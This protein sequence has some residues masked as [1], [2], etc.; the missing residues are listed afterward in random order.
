MR[1]VHAVVLLCVAMAQ[2]T[3]SV[4]PLTDMSDSSSAVDVRYV[5]PEHPDK[6]ECVLR[7]LA[8]LIVTV[9]LPD[10]VLAACTSVISPLP[11]PSSCAAAAAAAAAVV[12]AAALLLLPLLLRAAIALRFDRPA[13]EQAGDHRGRVRK[14]WQ[15]EP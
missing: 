1:V 14:Q 5:F 9:L 2:D 7:D 6:R 13:A 3:P 12:V 4:H 15:Y 8:Q 10:T 11:C